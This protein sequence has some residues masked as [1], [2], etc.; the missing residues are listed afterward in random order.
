M[1]RASPTKAAVFANQTPVRDE[2]AQ[3][4]KDLAVQCHRLAAHDKASGMGL[5]D[6]VDERFVRQHHAVT[7]ENPT[8]L[9]RFTIA[10][11]LTEYRAAR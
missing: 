8:T 6:V 10:A 1:E 2:K 7:S 9:R 5:R 4:A 11:I 3:T